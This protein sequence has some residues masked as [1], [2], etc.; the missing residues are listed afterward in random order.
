MAS[1]DP[2]LP[3]DHWVPARLIPTTGIGQAKERERRATEALLSVMHA[4]PEFAHAVLRHAG[5]PKGRTVHTFAEIRVPEAKGAAIPDGAAV[6]EGRG[7][8]R[9]RCFVEVKTGDDELNTDQVQTYLDL[10]NEHGID[11]VLTI[12]N[13]ITSSPE[14]TPVAL[15]P[16]RGRRPTGYPDLFHL[17]WWKVLTEAIIQHRHRG[18]SDPD[19]A[20][21]LGELITYL[22]H[23][24]SGVRGF[25]DMGP[26]WVAVRE[27]A[28]NKTL[29]AND[30]VVAD[31]AGRWGQLVEYLG[32]G[33][34]RDLGVRVESVRPRGQSHGD[35]LATT[36]RELADEALLRETVK[37]ADAVGDIE[38]VADLRAQKVFTSIEVPAPEDVQRPSARINWLLRQLAKADPRDL[39]MEAVYLRKVTTI[40][41]LDAVREDVAVLAHPNDPRQ[42]PRRL[43]VTMRREAGVKR[44]KGQ[45]AF[46]VETRR[47]LVDFYRV[48]QSL[49]PPT[50]RAPQLPDDAPSPVEPS[51]A[52]PAFSDLDTRDAGEGHIPEQSPIDGTPSESEERVGVDSDLQHSG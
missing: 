2:S 8:K 28:R 9:W 31:V 42:A 36:K 51:P 23:E 38:I 5:A 25:D 29:D 17:S 32:L 15:P 26:H 27:G 30:S 46:I 45:G 34:Q 21:I 12:S 33:L 4:V 35:W 41:P 1:P 37:V 40:A 47:Q 48:V 11:A 24:R 49:T 6:V 20:W 50:R 19:Q 7:G 44:S 39:S 18:V 10:G 16:R 43:R 22:D 13:Q 14:V 52:P 3:E